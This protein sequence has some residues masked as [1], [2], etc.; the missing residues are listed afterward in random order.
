MPIATAV[1][2]STLTLPCS[3][4][5]QSVK[6]EANP[7]GQTQQ[8]LQHRIG[9]FGCHDSPPQK[10]WRPGS[11]R[12]YLGPQLVQCM[13]NLYCAFMESWQPVVGELTTATHGTRLAS[14]T[15]QACSTSL[16]HLQLSTSSVPVRGTT[17]AASASTS[18]QDFRMAPAKCQSP[19][20]T[21][22]NK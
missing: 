1:Q 2:S 10:P 5:Q 15:S 4:I 12:S 9:S 19:L 20:H 17:F 14:C 11:G 22:M 3:T 8:N 6:P 21:Q 18:Y 16:E 7:L 13:G